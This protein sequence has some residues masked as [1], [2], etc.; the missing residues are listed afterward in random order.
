MS[1]VID[2]L[3]ALARD[4]R[5]LDAHAH[6]GALATLDAPA[7]DA[8]LARDPAAILAALGL[9]PALAC[10]VVAPEQDEPAPDESPADGEEETDPPATP[11]SSDERT[12]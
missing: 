10:I 9:P 7:R 5:P 12:A 3:E 4:P 8:L 1:H 11:D 6:A 2:I